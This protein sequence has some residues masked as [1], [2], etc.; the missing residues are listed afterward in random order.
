MTK[1]RS[2]RL[3]PA[4]TADRQGDQDP[5]SRRTGADVLPVLARRLPKVHNVRAGEML[6]DRG[7]ER[8]LR[9]EFGKR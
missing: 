5:Q 4:P 3:N 8:I 9:E 7:Q 1:D 6:A 2:S